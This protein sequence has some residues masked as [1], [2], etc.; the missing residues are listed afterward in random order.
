MKKRRCT[1][2]KRK[3]YVFEWETTKLCNKCIIRN[4]EKED[5]NENC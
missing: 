2:C 5:K 3:F 4:I 1:K